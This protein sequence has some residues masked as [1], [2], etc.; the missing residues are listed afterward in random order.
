MK[1]SLIPEGVTV[2]QVFDSL[3]RQSAAIKDFSGWAKVTGKFD[4]KTQSVTTVIRFIAPSRIKVDL[5][6]FAGIELASISLAGDSMTVYLPSYNGYLKGEDGEDLLKKFIPN[7]NF[8]VSRITSI[9]SVQLPPEDTL[10]EFQASLKK[11]E[12]RLELT[13]AKGNEV[14]RYLIEG[15]Q[16][17]IVEEDI[18]RDGTVIWQKKSRDY[19]SAGAGIFPREISVR[20]DRGSL[21]FVFYSVSVNS[22]LSGQDVA[23]DMPESAKLLQV[24]RK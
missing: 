17:L 9:F 14:Y 8:D 19:R 24:R 1:P 3:N 11:K 4:G 6:G 22:G 2:E 16:L 10:N 12:N 13:L 7:I 5:K 20:N 18:S 15:P 21:D 23:L